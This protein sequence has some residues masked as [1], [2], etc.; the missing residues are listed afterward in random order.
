[1]LA[2]GMTGAER[3]EAYARLVVRVGV[4]LQPGQDVGVVAQLEHA[5]LA[6]A[7]ARAAYAEGARYVD[8]L[9]Q[10]QQVKR[11]LVELGPEE[12]LDWTP[13]WLLARM[14]EL[15]ERRGARI[16][17]AGEAEPE[18]FADLDPSRVGAARMSA[19]TDA[20]LRHVTEGLTAWTIAGAPNE[21]WAR[22]VFGEPD[23]ER[24][25]DAVATA[26]RLDEPDPVAA[27]E[28][29]VKKLRARSAALNEGRFDAVRFRGPG[30]DL[31]VGL[32]P[33]SRWESAQAET[34]W[35]QRHVPNLPTEEAFTTPDRRRTEGFV[36]STRPLGL[37]GTIV[38]DLEI[39]FDG[40]RAVEVH[41]STG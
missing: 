3:L 4:N 33:G 6:R 14:D 10:D 1:M 13:P 23:V 21:G 11:A 16:T 9:Y 25:W 8:V 35:G 31:T 22:A 26:V 39:R 28:R 20:I 32:T 37:L 38:R 15:A 12:S 2:P 18:L 24:L 30:T 36:R 27:W 19:F 7:I 41:A 29:H 5:P 40:G 17:L 34:A